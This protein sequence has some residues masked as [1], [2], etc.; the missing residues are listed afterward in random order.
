M[1]PGGTDPLSGR[2]IEQVHLKLRVLEPSMHQLRVRLIHNSDK[3]CDTDCQATF[4]GKVE[5]CFRNL[6]KD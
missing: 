2:Q 5:Y 4:I 1:V 3:S 6:K